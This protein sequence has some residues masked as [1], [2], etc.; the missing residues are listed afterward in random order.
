[1]SNFCLKLE[2]EKNICDFRN[3]RNFVGDKSTKQKYCFTIVTEWCLK[4]GVNTRVFIR[5][6]DSR[7]YLKSGDGVTFDRN[8]SSALH[9]AC[10]SKREPEPYNNSGTTRVKYS[11]AI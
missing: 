11:C 3:H 4:K 1:M 5:A 7:C 6:I 2:N 8:I 9:V 10:V